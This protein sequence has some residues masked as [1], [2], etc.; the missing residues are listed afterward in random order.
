MAKFANNIFFD[1]FTLISPPL[2]I[3]FLFWVF[4]LKETKFCLCF[5]S[6]AGNLS[7]THKDKIRNRM[8]TLRLDARQLSD[9]FTLLVTDFFLNTIFTA[10]SLQNYISAKLKLY[11]VNI[12]G[13]IYWELSPQM[14]SPQMYAVFSW[15]LLTYK[16][17]SLNKLQK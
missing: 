2:V 14:L 8:A 6:F 10:H 17:K 11:Y 13:G 4:F 16:E 5:N 9:L 12:L 1:F 15:R 3:D 7:L